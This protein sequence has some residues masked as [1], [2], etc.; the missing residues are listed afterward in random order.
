MGDLRGNPICSVH[1]VNITLID[2]QVTVDPDN[3]LVNHG[4]EIQW[5]CGGAD[6]VGRFDADSATD[7][8]VWGAK[9]GAASRSKVI[10]QTGD[11][12]YTL[13]VFGATGRIEVDPHVVVT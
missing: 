12:K 13:W 8:P 1:Q 10:A 3:L 9:K 7:Q 11:Y 4:D 5:L 2:G 6:C